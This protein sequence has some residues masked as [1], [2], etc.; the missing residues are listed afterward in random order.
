MSTLQ[1]KKL[2]SG[3]DVRGIAVASESSPIT[4]TDEAVYAIV[5]SFVKWLS[6]KLNKP[7]LTIA[8]GNDVR[9]SAHR[10]LTQTVNA[11]QDSGCNV[12]YT[13]LCSTPSLFMLL[14]NSNWGCDASIMI[15][16]SHL[17]YDRNGLKFITPQGGLNGDDISKILEMAE[18]GDFLF[19]GKGNYE[20]R[21]YLDSYCN[22]LVKEVRNAC[23]C[24][25]PLDGRKIIVDAGNGAGGFFVD[26]VLKPLGANTR[27]SQFLEPDGTFPNHIPNPEDKDAI[28]SL[29]SAVRKHNAELGIIFDTDVDRAGAVDRFGNEINRNSLIALMSAI[30]LKDRK[31]TIVTDSVTS[32]GLTKFIE[33]LGGRHVRF[34][35]GYKYVID[36]AIRLNEEG[37]YTPLAMETSGHA[38]FKDNYF[39]DDGAYLV[40]R[41]LICL[42]DQA[43]KG[44]YLTSLISELEYPSEEDEVRIKFNPS[45]IDY[46]EEGKKVIADLKALAER[47][48][49]MTLAPDNYEGVKI[50]FDKNN[51]NGWFLLRQS[52]HDP[53][54]P[55]NFESYSAGGDKVIAKRLLSIIQNYSFLDTTN[56][57]NFITKT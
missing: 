7:T 12:I 6:T 57:I 5:R 29:S 42:Y 30:L 35:R 31:G 11:I 43:K 45:S 13:G 23:G 15:T 56:L 46:K 53:V 41:I 18:N 24:E 1:L 32:S 50:S 14:K 39:L 36:E 10:I 22:D 34:K 26:K 3:T 4:L 8:L 55:I 51:G 54:I 49:N 9:I 28:N 44:Q 21:R 40:T 2:K 47:S 33:N 25:R 17:P 27:G 37:E 16:A 52:V 19:G 48:D 20:E 38:A